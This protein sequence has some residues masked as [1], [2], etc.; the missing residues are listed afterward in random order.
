MTDECTIE[1]C[2]CKTSQQ[3]ITDATYPKEPK[4]RQK[5]RKEIVTHTPLWRAL[6]YDTFRGLL[7]MGTRRSGEALLKRRPKA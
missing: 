6:P 7:T 3:P 5:E 1:N 4:K 2:P